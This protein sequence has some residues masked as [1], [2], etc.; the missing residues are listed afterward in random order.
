VPLRLILNSNAYILGRPVLMT[1]GRR[2]L[3][4]GVARR[5]DQEISQMCALPQN[6]WL[7]CDAKALPVEKMHLNISD[8]RPQND[9]QSGVE[10][11]ARQ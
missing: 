4:S 2:N 10:A 5:F 3:N 11:N 6:R 9:I 7:F 1:A 8:S